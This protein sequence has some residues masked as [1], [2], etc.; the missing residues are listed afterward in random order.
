MR[1]FSFG[2]LT[3]ATALVFVPSAA[4]Q[5]DLPALIDRAVQAYGGEAQLAKMRARHNKC[6]GTL[7]VGKGVQVPFTQEVYFQ[8]PSQLKEIMS[9]EVN[10]AKQT[11]V[12]ILN[13]DKGVMHANG[14]MHDL[15]A[16]MLA[17][18]KEGVH[19]AQVTRFTALKERFF[20][21]RALPEGI[22]NSKP[23][24][25][26]RVSAEGFRDIDL[27][28]DKDTF[29]LAKTVRTARDFQTNT[30][31]KEEL[32]YSGWK[33]TDGIMTPMKL[34]VYRDGKKFMD[35]DAKEVSFSEKFDD[36]VFT[37]P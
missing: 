15:S 14:Q 24:L 28:L 4:A 19:F 7:T 12:S 27:Y 8:A 5:T 20:I 23:A 32:Y 2:S 10:G 13:G 9:A 34:T 22:V 3:L 31:M 33:V 18:L 29:L 16:A 1:R 25:G 26:I 37:N 11:V 17:E 30:L 36:S 6:E 21:L 35:V